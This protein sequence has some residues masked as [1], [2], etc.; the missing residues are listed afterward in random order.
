MDKDRKDALTNMWS[1]MVIAAYTKAFYEVVK[2]L[3]RYAGSDFDKRLEA[4]K[5]SAIR[6]VENAVLDGLPENEQLILVERARALIATA[7]DDARRQS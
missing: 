1:G 4:I 2:E 3:R 7:F 6:A 5:A